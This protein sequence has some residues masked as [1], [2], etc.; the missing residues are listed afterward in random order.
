MPEAQRPQGTHPGHRAIPFLLATLQLS[1]LLGA[2]GAPGTSQVRSWGGP[3]APT[4]SDE[5]MR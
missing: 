4:R 2:S 3:G 5:E 1:G